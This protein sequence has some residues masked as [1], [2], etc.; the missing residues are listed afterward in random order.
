[1]SNSHRNGVRVSAAALAVVAAG[2]A[3]ALHIGKL[4]AAV[5]ALQSGLGISLVEAGF[6]L[7]LI[8]VAGMSLGIFVGLAADAIGLRRSMLM[9]LVLVSS[10][11]LLGGFVGTS[12]H[13]KAH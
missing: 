6:L 5:P 9:G 4:P 3:A 12:I 2:V 13:D 7:S 11:S 10:A 1:M 8:Q